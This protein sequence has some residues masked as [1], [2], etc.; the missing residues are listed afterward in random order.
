MIALPRT[1]LLSCALLRSC[2]TLTLACAVTQCELSSAVAQGS[3]ELSAQRA[4]GQDR[5][6]RLERL[7]RRSQAR[8]AT[9]LQ[10]TDRRAR[11]SMALINGRKTSELPRVRR[12]WGVDIF[13]AT[14]L[15]TGLTGRYSFNE[16]WQLGLNVGGGDISDSVK[17][18]ER[19]ITLEL[20]EPAV[21]AQVEALYLPRAGS[22]SPF[23]ALGARYLQGLGRIT[24]NQA[25]L[26]GGGGL[27]GLVTDVVNNVTGQAST[28]QVSE[29]GEVE[30][31][32]LSA[33]V[34][35]DYQALGNGFH[36]RIGLSY[37]YPLFAGHRDSS[38]GQNLT[39]RA[40]A[41]EWAKRDLTWDLELSIG[42]SL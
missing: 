35:Y 20:P 26:S 39:T 36:A 14:E 18:L 28:Q 3:S 1:W 31:H 10:L 42:W 34:G 6:C 32:L 29:S 37:H 17:Q 25:P 23:I 16:N 2:L 41:L 27:I 22:S 7:K 15:I 38:S 12:P 40:S 21:S 4:C 13:A 9:R 8:S 24:D 19:T 5:R 33:K 11:E 30:M